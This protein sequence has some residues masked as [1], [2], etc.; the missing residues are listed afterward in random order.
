MA[1][2]IKVFET[3]NGT[4]YRVRFRLG[5]QET[6]ETFVREE[7]AEVFRD[8][9]GDGRGDR[10]GC[11]LSWLEDR[12]A[13]AQ[14]GRETVLFGDWFEE[15]V[16]QLTGVTPRTRGD[17]RSLHRRYLSE[18]D[19]LPLPLLQR[20][21]VTK[22]VNEMDRAGRSPKTIKQTIH[23]L[24]SCLGL[25]VDEGKMTTNPCKRVRLP[26]QTIESVEPRFLTH[27]EAAALIEAHPAHY[28][29]LVTFLFGTGERWSEAT[30]QFGRHISLTNGTSRVEQA[31]KRVPNNGLVL[32]PPK[33]PRAKRTVNAATAALVA[34]EPLIRRPGDLVFVTRSG[35]KVSHANFYNNVW[36]P[37]VERSGLGGWVGEGGG[38]RTWKGPRIHDARH[39][40]ASWLIS[41]GMSLEA[42]QDQLGHESIL[43]TR[44]VYGHL[45]PALGVAVG[46]SASAAMERVLAARPA[47]LELPQSGS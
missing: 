13:A 42:V 18:L 45:L 19:S 28:R 17:Y 44:K 46:R 4:R 34:V 30:A 31:W 7:D 25:A 35:G 29:P 6:S 24:S 5:T 16:D 2:Q 20:G 22:I 43:T 3:E 41:D 47:A 1:R 10:V 21:Q 26:E 40:H 14:Q 8:I 12:K 37:A 39:S 33:T 15:Y 9:L 36:Q 38:G 23:L 27:E 11:A 32:G